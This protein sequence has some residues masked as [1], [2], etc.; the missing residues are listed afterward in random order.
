MREDSEGNFYVGPYVDSNGTAYPRYKA[1][2]YKSLGP[3]NHGPFESTSD[4]YA[5]ISQLNRQFTL[6]DPEE[7]GDRDESVAEYE[8]LAEFAPKIVVEE[9]ANGPFVINH[10]DLTL[11]NILVRK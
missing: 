5:A 7:E 3:E 10:N 11:R 4:W 2:A 6:E 8:L 1:E 9:Y